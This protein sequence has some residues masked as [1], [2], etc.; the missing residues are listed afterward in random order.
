MSDVYPSVDLFAAQVI[1]ASGNATSASTL[2]TGYLRQ[3][4]VYV[5]NAGTST[6]GTIAI[7]GSHTTGKTL[8]KTIHTFNL[9][10]GGKFG[11]GIEK[12]D[13]PEYMWA[14]V[15]N[16]DGTHTAIVTVTLVLYR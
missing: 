13:I 1:D 5:G 10:A 6:D 11:I 15:T 2:E 12:V 14:V 16:N 4:D 8:E 7:K 3:I 9:A